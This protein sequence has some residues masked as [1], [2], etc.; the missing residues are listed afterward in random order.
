M[1]T[2]HGGVILAGGKGQRLLP[3]TAKTPKPLLCVD[4]K[5]PFER[6]IALLKSANVQ[7]IAVTTGYL[8]EEI[9]NFTF[10]GINEVD[11]N[12]YRETTPKGTA[13]SV[14]EILPKLD[15]DFFV[16]SG[17]LV[18]DIDLEQMMRFHK[19]M[20]AAVTI[21]S[22]KSYF[23]TEY[24]TIISE[25]SSVTSFREKPSWKQVISTKINAGIYIINRE[26][27][28]KHK[29]NVEDFAADYFPKLLSSGEKIYTFDLSGYW[30]DVGTHESYLSCNM[31][32]SENKNVFGDYISISP[33]AKIESSVIMN[34]VRV[35]KGTRIKSS[36]VGE[37]SS[38]GKDCIIEN[39]VIG[40]DTLICDFAKVEKNSVVSEDSIIGAGKTVKG[41]ESE[42]ELF[43]DSGL[44]S[45]EEETEE[46]T[47]VLAK[48]I[49]N[50]SNNSS[51]YIFNDGEEKSKR[52]SESLFEK[53]LRFGANAF[54]EGA[55]CAPVASFSSISDDCYSVF[56]ESNE[57]ESSCL[58]FDANGLPL[59]REKQIKCKKS[60]KSFSSDEKTYSQTVFSKKH[61]IEHSETYK[62]R[63]SSFLLSSVSE[64]AFSETTKAQDE[65]YISSKNIPSLIFREILENSGIKCS[66]DEEGKQNSFFI[67]KNGDDVYFIT[68]K[69]KKLDKMHLLQICFKN[70][71][72]KN[73]YLPDFCPNALKNAVVSS[74]SSFELYDDSESG[75][76]KDGSIYR[77][78]DG[79]SIA[80]ACVCCCI[81][82]KSSLPELSEEENAFSFSE[83]SIPYSGNKGFAFEKLLS[84]L[85]ESSKN[86]ISFS[87]E[88]GIVSILPQYKNEFRIFAEAVSAEAAE[89]LIFEAETTFRKLTEE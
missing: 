79:I 40:P 5:T 78:S 66:F 24:G 1:Q 61:Q 88:N 17:D 71:P 45:F 11:I 83:K 22:V 44:V 64:N 63:L 4:G 51:V 68:E 57:S 56:V 21:A 35:G 59:S 70:L 12:Y 27:M 14:I 31:H 81:R 46:K 69:G 39:A 84:A 67:S 33:D 89:E 38:I 48:A 10:D 86:G 23:P 28:K 72:Q 29:E 43:S 18:F 75:R 25:N 26:T 37:G 47:I 77:F 20:K 16:L 54:F 13:G 55:S 76:K 42:N 2:Q 58:I 85:C 53:A 60:L 34:G 49:S 19:E 65:F 15:E 74:G 7:S 9:E 8:G 32:F 3:L 30:C 52:I 36:I 82:K 62:N 87:R 41:K 73:A 80:I 50:V 6:C